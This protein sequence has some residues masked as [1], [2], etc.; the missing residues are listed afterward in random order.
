MVQSSLFEAD[1][2]HALI[3]GYSIGER[4]LPKVKDDVKVV[5]DFTSRN[6]FDS[7]KVL[8]DSEATSEAIID[9]FTDHEKRCNDH[10]KKNSNKKYFL[11]VYYSGHGG[12]LYGT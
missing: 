9:F 6:N 5:E 12:I 3:I 1:E 8:Q 11:L 10:G 7:I 4:S 2:R